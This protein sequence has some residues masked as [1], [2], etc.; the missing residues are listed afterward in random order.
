MTSVACGIIASS[1]FLGIPA[2]HSAPADRVET[3]TRDCA[4]ES[5]VTITADGVERGYDVATGKVLDR[6]QRECSQMQ[7][8]KTGGVSAASYKPAEIWFTS[9]GT[10]KRI[11]DSHGTFNGQVN[12]KSKGLPIA[13]SYK[14]NPVM[15]K[16]P[17]GKVV[18]HTV[19]NPPNCSSYHTELPGYLFHGSCG[20][21]T[22]QVRYSLTGTLDFITKV[23]GKAAQ[24]RV[25]WKVY[26]T[27]T[28]V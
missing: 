8:P 10:T 14:L 4:M 26:Y 3:P 16:L 18:E 20:G 5:T 17:R 2:A 24:G 27:I 7:P 13:W 1:C 12:Y 6:P 28:F 19:R 15:Q 11:T 21:Q 25:T 23:G 22:N 9:R